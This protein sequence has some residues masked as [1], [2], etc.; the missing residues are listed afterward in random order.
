MLRVRRDNCP[1][2]WAEALAFGSWVKKHQLAH[3]V[4]LHPWYSILLSREVLYG[5]HHPIVISR[6]KEKKIGLTTLTHD[7]P[8]PTNG[9]HDRVLPAMMMDV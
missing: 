1:V 9:I 6:E 2:P 8:H 7:N 4:Q 5:S 3:V